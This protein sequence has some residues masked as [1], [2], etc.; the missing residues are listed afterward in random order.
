M[1]KRL[2]QLHEIAKLFELRI[3]KV[4]GM[5]LDLQFI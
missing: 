3:K 1:K 5:P 4:W 2:A